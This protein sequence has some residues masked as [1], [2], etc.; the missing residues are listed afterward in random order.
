MHADHLQNAEAMI[1]PTTEGILNILRAAVQV[2]TVRRVVHINSLAAIHLHDPTITNGVGNVYDET[3]WN[4]LDYETATTTKNHDRQYA[5][6]E[7]PALRTKPDC[8]R[9]QRSIANS[10]PTNSCKTTSPILTS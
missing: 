2:P 6:S 5:Y 1:Q 8:Q 3:C 7:L 4:H 10:S 9:S